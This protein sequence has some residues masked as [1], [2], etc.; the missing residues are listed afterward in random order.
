MKALFIPIIFLLLCASCSNPPLRGGDILGAEEFVM[1]SFKIREGKCAILELEG[2][3]TEPISAELLDEYDDLI[4]E[5]DL[6]K[7]AV[8]HPTRLDI[9]NSVQKIGS[10]MG[11]P[12]IGGAVQLPELE[13]VCVKGLTI[14]QARQ[15]I[16]EQ[17]D[18]SIQDTEVFV[19]YG[20]RVERKVQFI[21][22]VGNTH[23]SIDGKKRLYDVL[24]IAK[25][26]PNANLFKSYVV[27]DEQLL[28]V[29][30]YRLVKRGTW[31]KIS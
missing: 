13:P 11:F 1:D 26:A 14:E 7:I 29:D 10:T 17:Y 12:V 28:P 20:E 21:G 25:L 31:G 15:K 16:Q 24:S 4:Q 2:K 18:K 6:L 27:R 22:L 23:V 5:G 30:L 3:P 8:H 9:S 19:S